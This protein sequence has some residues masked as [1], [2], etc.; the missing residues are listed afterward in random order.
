MECV[1]NLEFYYDL[2]V[3]NLFIVSFLLVLKYLML[4]KQNQNR[5]VSSHRWFA[6]MFENM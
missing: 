6:F 1:L 3:S 2:F 4:L 5:F